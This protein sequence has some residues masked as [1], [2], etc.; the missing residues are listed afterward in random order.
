[1]GASRYFN[2]PGIK[3]WIK[4]INITKLIPLSTAAASILFDDM[5][6]TTKAKM[7]ASI[8]ILIDRTIISKKP[9]ETSPFSVKNEGSTTN[10]MDD[11]RVGRPQTPD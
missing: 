1:M 11:F 2:S 9:I 7:G 6:S 5:H 3:N 8:D 10:L 4:A